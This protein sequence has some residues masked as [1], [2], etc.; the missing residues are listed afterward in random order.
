MTEFY[1][2]TESIITVMR[3]IIHMKCMTIMHTESTAT[4]IMIIKSI[5]IHMK[6][7]FT[8]IKSTAMIM[9]N[10]AATITLT[11]MKSMIMIMESI[12]AAATTMALTLII[13]TMKAITMRQWNAAR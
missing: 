2:K 12:A 6:H 9:R 7:I 11:F 5:I 13:T 10:T 1:K 3:N 4:V 8:I